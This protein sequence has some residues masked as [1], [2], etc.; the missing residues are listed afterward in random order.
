[1]LLMTVPARVVAWAKF[2]RAQ[3]AIMNRSVEKS[4]C[5]TEPASPQ[6]R[7]TAVPYPCLETV[8]LGSVPY[9]GK[10]YFMK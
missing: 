2:G 6:R 4:L 10:R 8:R 9:V 7:R 3:Q 1:V 5:R